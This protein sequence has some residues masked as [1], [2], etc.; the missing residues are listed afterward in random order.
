MGKV[1]G[2]REPLEPS[3]TASGW[4][5]DP[6]SWVKTGPVSVD[7]LAPAKPRGSSFAPDDQVRIVGVHPWSGQSGTITGLCR[8][9]ARLGLDRWPARRVHD[10]RRGREEPL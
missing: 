7:A 2:E 8:Q 6:S 3:V 4:Y 9:A 5:A 10:R 1:R